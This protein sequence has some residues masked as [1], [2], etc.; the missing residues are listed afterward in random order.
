MKIN[1]KIYELRKGFNLSQEEL[2]DRIGVSRQTVSKWETGESCPDFD[3]IIPLCEIFGMTPDELLTDKKSLKENSNEKEKIDTVKVLLIC[4]SIFLYFVS[5]VS[6]IILEEYFNVNDGLSAATFLIFCG[7]ATV[8]IV[9]V[10]MTRANKKNKEDK[11]NSLVDEIISIVSL[12]TVCIY[13]II[14]FLTGKWH[15][16][17]MI[18]IIYA[19]IVKIIQLV[20]HLRKGSNY[21]KE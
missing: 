7:I 15:L 4:L 16:T 14:S 3:K 13:L 5:V 10:C 2:A 8:I 21:E 12:M 6:V 17:W 20:F 11:K 19:I 1:E 18:W 9:Y